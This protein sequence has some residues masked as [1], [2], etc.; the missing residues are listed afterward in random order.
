M[1]LDSYLFALGYCQSRTRAQ[2]LI[3]IGA[4]KVNGV[5]VD[6]V[7]TDIKSDVHIEILKESFASLGGFK[8]EKALSEFK[9]E[10][11]DMVCLDVGASNGGFTEQLLKN[12]AKKVYA[13]DVG[14]CALPDYLKED[15]RVEIMDNTNARYVT[16]KDFMEKIELAV[17]DV[18]FISLKLILPPVCALMKNCGKIIALIKPQFECSK[19]DLTKKGIIKTK[20]ITERAV[21]GIRDFC[22]KLGLSVLGLTETPRLFENKNEEFLIYLK[23]NR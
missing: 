18:S 20:K 21:Q 9:C 15:S 5:V 6:K 4:V 3:K 17:I 14:D 1:R 22:V 10:V 13:L 2:N 23:I 16:E 11:S 12:G 7:G 8:L 19:S